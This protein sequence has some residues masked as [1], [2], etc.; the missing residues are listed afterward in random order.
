MKTL[1]CNNCVM[2]TSDRDISFDSNGICNHCRD[3]VQQLPKFK[4]TEAVANKQLQQAIDTIHSRSK[5]RKFDAVIGLSGGVDSSYLAHLAC[6]HG[7]KPLIVHFD[8]GW[9][10]ETAVS[11]IRKIVE[12]L[13]LEYST[14]VINWNEFKN[15][16]RAFIKASVIDIELLTDYAI[17][18][19]L[20]QI[21][22]KEGIPYVLSG[23]N[24]ATEHGMPQAW[25]W[26]KG[27]VRNIRG[28]NAHFGEM[29][30]KSFPTTSRWAINPNKRPIRPGSVIK[31]LNLIHYKKDDAI[32]TLQEE[33]DWEYYGGK[34]YESTFTKFYQA[35]ILPQKFGIDKRR[36]HLSAQIRNDEIDRK[37]ALKELEIPL[38]NQLELKQD[39]EFVLKKLG[40]SEAEFDAIMQA[41][42]IP[43][44]HY[45]AY[46]NTPATKAKK[47]LKQIIPSSIWNAMRDAIYGKQ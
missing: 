1:I 14:Y 8:N 47:T 7:L 37:T 32:R 39:K 33:Y 24:Y 34:H 12:K 11:N 29:K 38:Y 27:D 4:P 21:T 23:D 22:R 35:H 13:G 26:H 5:G 9:N 42:P 44:D 17:F 6:S 45:P 20:S 25:T 18:S 31:L 2:D 40:F 43:H 36:V 28:I 41:P 30:I 15:L 10:S 3:A 19:A 16:Q 46:N